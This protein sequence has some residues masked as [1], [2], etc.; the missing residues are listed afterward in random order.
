MTMEVEGAFTH[1]LAIAIPASLVFDIPHLR[2]KTQRI[3]MV[4]RAAAI[5][6]V[7]EIIVYPDSPNRDQSVE[8]RLI[9]VILSYM[10]TPQYLRRRLFRLMPELE[11]A[12]ILPPLR[13]PHHPLRNRVRDLVEGEYREGVVISQTKKGASVDVGVERPA[14]VRGA[15]L[16]INTRTTVQLSRKRRVLEGRLADRPE[17]RSYWGYR[18]TSSDITLGQLLQKR[19]FD[20]VVATSKRGS[21]LHQVACKLS[22][23]WRT[24]QRIL[25]AFG[26]PTR[27]LYDIIKRENL[28]LSDLADFAVNIFPRQKVE[29]VRTEEAVYVSLGALFLVAAKG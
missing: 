19:S 8:T 17:I 24:S 11:Y 6:G 10:E 9:S 12:G 29:T 15:T 22:D 2:E 26:A 23:R 13:T 14:L 1:D 21:P 3:G 4:G 27:G 18:V 7:D 25:V 20:L 5:F 28:K 16:P